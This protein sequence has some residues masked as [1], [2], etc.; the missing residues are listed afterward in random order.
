MSST[1]NIS[2]PSDANATSNIIDNVN[3]GSTSQNNDGETAINW[4]TLL[5]LQ[6]AGLFILAGLAEIGGG[7]L[8]WQAVREGKAA[9]WAGLGSITLIAYGFIVTLQPLNDFGRLYAVYGGVFIGLSYLWGYVADGMKLDRG[10][11]IGSFLA[12]GGVCVKL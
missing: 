3:G 7:W 11:L 12:L 4:T 10:D 8:V 2:T 6:V 5:V 9:W 1:S